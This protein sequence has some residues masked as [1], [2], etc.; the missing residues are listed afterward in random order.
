[1]VVR[2]RGFDSRHLHHIACDARSLCPVLRSRRSRPHASLVR[3]GSPLAPSCATIAVMGQLLDAERPRTIE[4]VVRRLGM[5][6]EDPTAV[7]ARTEHLVLWSRLGGRFRVDDLDRL[8][9]RDRVLFEYWVHIVPMDDYPTPSGVD[10][11][12]S[13][14]DRPGPPR[15]RPG[16]AGSRTT[17]SASTC[18]PSSASR[19][20]PV[21]ATSMIEP[22]SRGGPAA[23]TTTGRGTSGCSSTSSGIRARSP[24]WGVTGTSAS[25]IWR[26]APIPPTCGRSPARELRADPHRP[27]A[28]G[29]RRGHTGGVRR[30]FTQRAP[31]LA[32]ALS[33]PG[34]GGRRG[35]R[36]GRRAAG[37]AR[38]HTGILLAAVPWTA[39]TSA[40]AVRLYLI[41]GSRPHRAA[42]RDAPPGPRSTCRRR[43][44]SSATSSCRSCAAIVSWD[45]SIRRSTGRPGRCACT[46]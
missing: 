28:A 3:P 12:L 35:P 40:L 10:A 36:G 1:M 16:V 45:G 4:Q 6:Q 18:W 7:V 32:S 34:R 19:T 11:R 33:R 44:A 31:G 13:T 46:P 17:P 25:G 26:R 9:Y 15:V 23:G 5:V 29:P 8:L 14:E 24:S 30:L 42:L 2:R 43:N 38:T 22:S 21:P 20:P 41:L 39:L 27:S 37:A